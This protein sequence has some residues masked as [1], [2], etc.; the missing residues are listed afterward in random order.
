MYHTQ[1][2]AA[3]HR[4]CALSSSRFIHEK[5]WLH[6]YVLSS[7]RFTH[8]KGGYKCI[9]RI[10]NFK[11]STMQHLSGPAVGS[12]ARQLASEPCH[13]KGPSPFALGVLQNTLQGILAKSRM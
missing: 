8:I 3:T 10:K 7:S 5:G 11:D 4:R 13:G 12:Y 1:K 9:V 2:R 6:M